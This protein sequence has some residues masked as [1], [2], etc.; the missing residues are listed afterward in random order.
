MSISGHFKFADFYSGAH[1]TIPS[2]LSKTPNSQP[3]VEKGLGK[4]YW[5]NPDHKWYT[6]LGVFMG[7]PSGMVSTKDSI[8]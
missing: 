2:Y 4:Y 8:A 6:S 7:A 1:F 3:G 5:P